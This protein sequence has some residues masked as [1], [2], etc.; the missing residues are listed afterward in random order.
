[1]EIRI[2]KRRRWWRSCTYNG[3]EAPATH[4]VAYSDYVYEYYC[5]PHFNEW[6]ENQQTQTRYFKCHTKSEHE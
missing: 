5:E 4:H 3:C 1:M 2:L 6:W